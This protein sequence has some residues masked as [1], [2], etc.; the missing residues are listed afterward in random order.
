MTHKSAF[1][2]IV[3]RPNTGKSTLLNAL[4]GKK[5]AI[6]SQH[7]NTTRK[8]IRGIVT[9]PE[10]QLIFV[11]T[12]GLHKPKTMLGGALNDV[13]SES[14][15]SVDIIVQC[16]P[17]TDPVGSGDGHIAAMIA[18]QKSALKICVVTMVDRVEKKRVPEQ[19][20]AASD[21]AKRAG[22]EWDEIVPLSAITGEQVE[23]LIELLANRAAE[24]PAFYPEEMSSDQELEDEIAELIREAT[25]SN[26]LQEV[27]HSIA[28]VIDEMSEREEGKLL[29][30]HASLIVERDS[31]KGIIIGNKG[32]NLKEIGTKARREIELKLDRKVFLSL[33]VKVLPNWQRDAKALS[34]LGFIQR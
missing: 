24:G 20:I 3:G 30:I 23:L 15:D 8:A 4:V 2:S 34:K 22:F 1:I 26:L 5:V 28:V 11:D 10:F 19:L 6:T 27:P 17:A 31:Q 14:I 16:I 12:P 33:H 25:I 21:L 29:D 9:R 18:A 13:V 7:P 32:A